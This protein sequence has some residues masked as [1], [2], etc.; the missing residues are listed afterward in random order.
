MNES[1]T[2]RFMKAVG[3]YEP[4]EKLVNKLTVYLN[5]LQQS[6]ENRR[7]LEALTDPTLIDRMYRDEFEQR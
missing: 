4:I 2:I 3:L 6:R 1:N 7:K 5:D